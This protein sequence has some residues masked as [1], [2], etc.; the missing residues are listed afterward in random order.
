MP[1]QRVTGGLSFHSEFCK[2]PPGEVLWKG[3][4][5]SSQD[6]HLT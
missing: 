6:I 2:Q 4:A 3:Q 1:N 5:E